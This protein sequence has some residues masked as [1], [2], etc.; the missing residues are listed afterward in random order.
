LPTAAHTSMLLHPDHRSQ[1]RLALTL[2]ALLALLLLTTTQFSVPAFLP[3]EK[4]YAWLHTA[5]ETFSISVAGLIFAVGWSAPRNRMPRV[6]ALLSCA[7]LGIAVLDFSHAMMFPGMPGYNGSGNVQISIAFWLGARTL[8]ALALLA[9]ALLPWSNATFK[10]KYSLVIIVLASVAAFHLAV[11]AAAPH[12]ESLFH[13]ELGLTPLK[14]AY[15]YLLMTAYLA[16]ALLFARQ[17]GHTRYF[18]ASS[19]MAAA[20]IMAM[21]EFSFTLYGQPTDIYNLIGHIYKVIAYIFLYYALFVETIQA[22]YLELKTSRQQLAGALRSKDQQAQALHKLSLAVEQ[23]PKPMLITNREGAIEYVNQAFVNTSGYS[24]QE[25]LGQNPRF[26][27]SGKTSTS[28]Y[29]SMWNAL[30]KGEAWQGEVV[31][32]RKNGTDYIERILIYPIKNEA[33]QVT[34][35]LSHKDDVTEEKAAAERIRLLSQFDTVTGLPNQTSM[36]AMLRHAIDLA[37]HHN[38]PMALLSVN[39]DNFRVVNE[40]LGHAAGDQI[41]KQAA[42]RLVELSTDKDTVARVSGDHFVMILPGAD[43]A[44]ATVKAAQINVAFQ[45]PFILEHRPVIATASIGIALHPDDGRT[46]N[47]LLA[48]SEAAMF[49]AK[50]EGRNTYRFFTP[51]LQKSSARML[52]LSAALQQAI[53]LGQLRL[54]YQPQIDLRSGTVYGAEALVRWRHPELG[55]VSPAE[56]IPVAEHYGLIDELGEWILETALKQTAAWLT[57]GMPELLIAINLS[58]VQFNTPNLAQRIMTIVQRTGANPHALEL[59]LTEAVAMRDPESANAIMQSLRK[60]GFRLSIDD[61]GTGYSSLSYLR[62]FNI[63]KLKIDRSFIIELDQSA[64]DQAIVSAI[65]QM[66]HSLGMVTLA[67]GVETSGQLQ[68]LR[69][70]GCD[71]IQGYYYSKPLDPIDFETFVRAHHG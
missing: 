59:E 37:S 50:T 68:V 20:A 27:Q 71:A 22:P 41:L 69:E 10:P 58:A 52:E 17:L 43:Q 13:T 7:F 16:S 34:H 9:A 46:G 12:L 70:K 8:G 60:Y 57:S 1:A 66:A 64:N 24:L 11:H 54:V 4:S 45:K 25:I 32:R 49:H 31:N 5:L 47:V 42:E 35:Y 3:H 2:T 61:F 63:D 36:R 21:S 55:E 23:S 33:G 26:L 48:C 29:T 51:A 28:T 62:K 15:E 53:K 65:I 38:D 56:F 14:K 39:L 6:V 19:F 40:T 18:N 44:V 67:E 30:K